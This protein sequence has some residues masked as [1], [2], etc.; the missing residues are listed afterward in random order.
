MKIKI[1][2]IVACATVAMTTITAPTTVQA[3][4]GD[5]AAGLFGGFVA[6]AIVGSAIAPRPYYGPPPVY[7]APAP[8]YAGECYWTRGRPMWNGY[9]WVRPR[10]QVCD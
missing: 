7:V 9:A 5:V 3:G 2:V 4:S 10:I 6:G 8:V 1:S